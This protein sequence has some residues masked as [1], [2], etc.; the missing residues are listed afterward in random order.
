MFSKVDFL[1]Y[2]G[3]RKKFYDKLS[4]FTVDINHMSEA[5][6]IDKDFID[7]IEVNFGYY[8]TRRTESKKFTKQ[9]NRE[10]KEL[11]K[12][13]LP[14][15]KSLFDYKGPTVYWFKINYK[16]GLSNDDI[17]NYYSTKKEQWKGK[18]WWTQ[19]NMKRKNSTTEI[20]YLGKIETA[21]ENRFIQHIGL[22]HEFSTS[23]KLQ[24][25]LPTDKLSLTFQFLK[26]DI[27]WKAYAEDI[28][29]VLWDYKKPLLGASPRIKTT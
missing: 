17:L 13:V 11:I 10:Y 24:K 4:E 29:K 9:E 16:N 26:L 7:R 20:L 14:E 21:L 15:T 22:G 6:E 2:V 3:E 25:W 5:I 1:H 23:L 27:K 18:G 8:L 19:V 28:E 12:K